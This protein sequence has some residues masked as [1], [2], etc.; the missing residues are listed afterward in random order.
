MEAGAAE[1]NEV[2]PAELGAAGA[3]TRTSG[4]PEAAGLHYHIRCGATALRGDLSFFAVSIPFCLQR[5]QRASGGARCGP[6]PWAT[7]PLLAAIP[8]SAG[9][10]PYIAGLH[11]R[12][13]RSSCLTLRAAGHT[14][15][16]GPTAAT[17][18]GACGRGSA[19]QCG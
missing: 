1:E 4:P 10:Q 5:P 7:H 11:L 3:L 15:A 14:S 9:H 19:Q 18:A 6:A 17:T 2:M 16:R 12:C 13:D 8:F